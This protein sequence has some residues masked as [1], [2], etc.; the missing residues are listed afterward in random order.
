MVLIFVPTAIGQ[1]LKYSSQKKFV[2]STVLLHRQTEEFENLYPV[3]FE[4]PHCPNENE[5]KIK[6]KNCKEDLYVDVSKFND[7][8][9]NQNV[10]NKR[11]EN[12]YCIKCHTSKNVK[13]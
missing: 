3:C 8:N 9:K 6:C 10:K 2:D 7:S 13:N 11:I 1:Y 5:E 12:L 4:N